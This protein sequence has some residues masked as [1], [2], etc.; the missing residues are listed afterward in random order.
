MLEPTGEQVGRIEPSQTQG[1]GEGRGEAVALKVTEQ[2]QGQGREGQV[3]EECRTIL[4]L[5]KAKGNQ[6]AEPRSG[7]TALL[8]WG[9][10]G[11]PLHGCLWLPIPG[12]WAG[13]QMDSPGL[14]QFIGTPAGEK[15]PPAPFPGQSLCPWPAE[16]DLRPGVQW[17]GLTL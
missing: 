5:H 1:Q 8:T 6:H 10:A 17:L 12:Q 15:Q 13:G 7:Q 16:G 4:S 11:H 2:G 3:R 9:E 14:A